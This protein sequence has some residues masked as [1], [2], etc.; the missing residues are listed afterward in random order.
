[1]RDYIKNKKTVV[2][3]NKYIACPEMQR[4]QGILGINKNRTKKK[5]IVG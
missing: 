3:K 2:Y 4:G 1:M 5:K